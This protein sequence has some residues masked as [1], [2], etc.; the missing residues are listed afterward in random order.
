MNSKN[1][2]D[3]KNQKL[4]QMFDSTDLKEAVSNI[5]DSGMKDDTLALLCARTHGPPSWHL[6]WTWKKL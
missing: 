3:L 6:G 1:N 4:L 2:Y 5:Y